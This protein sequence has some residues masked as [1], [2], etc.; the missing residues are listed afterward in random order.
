MKTKDVFV[1]S[2]QEGVEKVMQENYAYLME[3]RLKIFKFNK[4]I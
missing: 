1:R 2:N 4:I 3:S